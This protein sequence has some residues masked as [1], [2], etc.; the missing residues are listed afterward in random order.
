MLRL[1]ITEFKNQEACYQRDGLF[2]AIRKRLPNNAAGVLRP[3]KQEDLY[4]I[5]S[6]VQFLDYPDADNVQ[7]RLLSRN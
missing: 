6:T 3:Q 1:V 5:V 7:P 2:A 4:E